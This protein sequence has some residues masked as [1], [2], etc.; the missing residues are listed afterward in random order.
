MGCVES[1]FSPP[2]A[3]ITSCDIHPRESTYSHSFAP[4]S[5]ATSSAHRQNLDSRIRC[6]PGSLCIE[7]SSRR[8]QPHAHPTKMWE[9]DPESKSKVP[10]TPP[11]PSHSPSTPDPLALPITC[12]ADPLNSTAPHTAIPRPQQILHRLLGALAA[13]GVPQIRHLHLPLMCGVASQLGR[14]HFVR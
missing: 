5:L 10:L 8:P 11:Y 1:Q 2:S 4:S 7:D 13:M 6:A 9:V 3:P 14:A 12:S